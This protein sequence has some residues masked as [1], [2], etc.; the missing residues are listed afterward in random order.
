MSGVLEIFPFSRLSAR[1]SADASVY[2]QQNII[3]GSAWWAPSGAPAGVYSNARP[4]FAG[5]GAAGLFDVWRPAGHRFGITGGWRGEYWWYEAGNTGNSF[6]GA[7]DNV[8]SS[9]PFA[10]FYAEMAYPG[11]R[12]T[13]QFLASRF[14]SKEIS[15]W[16]R[17]P[18]DYGE[19][20]FAAQGGVLL[21]GR[22]Q[23]EANITSN[24]F[25]GLYGRYSYQNASG[26]FDAQSQSA[27]RRPMDVNVVENTLTLQLQM[28][29]LFW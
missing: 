14:V 1:L 23:G 15:G 22:I 3:Y 4:G 27:G 12:S 17:Q 10:G 5:F 6:V 25:F 26:V 21:E 13:W 7:E 16:V 20:H 29:Y 9:I 28:T 2:G 11:W 18:H 24:L 8:S 19:Y